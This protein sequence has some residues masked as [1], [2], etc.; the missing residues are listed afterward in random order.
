MGQ[1]YDKTYAER[2]AAFRKKQAASESSEESSP[3]AKKALLR[4]RYLAEEVAPGLTRGDMVKSTASATRQRFGEAESALGD[5]LQQNRLQA[6]RQAGW[7]DQYRQAIA[8]AGQR[9]AQQTSAAVQGVQSLQ[10]GLDASAAKQWAGEQGAMSADAANRGASTDPKLATQAHNASNVRNVLTGS[11]G[12]MLANSGN[13]QQAN[14][15]DRGVTSVQQKGEALAQRGRERSDLQKQR[16]RLKR[17]KGDF[18]VTYANT[19]KTGAED[20]ALKRAL[21]IAQVGETAADTANTKAATQKTKAE[22]T[23][24]AL[25]TAYFAKYGKY[26]SSGAQELDPLEQYRLD[27]AKKHGGKFPG[28]ESS[29]SSTD[30]GKDEFGNT[31]RQQRQATSSFRKVIADATALKAHAPK[32]LSDAELV[33]FIYNGVAGEHGTVDIDIIRAGVQ[34]AV[35]GGVPAKLAKR[36][37]KFGIK[38]KIYRP[39]AAGG[40]TAVEGG[41][42]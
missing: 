18:K 6:N 19:L 35:Y 38:P 23:K 33:K 24:T 1:K 32:G 5:S 12:A 8:Q 4:K 40:G 41:G 42:V 20:S 29:G 21:T 7:Y 22:T 11:F 10:T 17:E 34:R 36:I 30:S 28:T 39:P 2:V 25:E 14:L 13:A 27:Y 3:E 16:V 31:P 15:S 9:Q 37:R 26:P